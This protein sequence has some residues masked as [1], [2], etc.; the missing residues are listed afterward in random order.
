MW[1][2]SPASCGE[3][4]APPQPVVPPRRRLGRAGNKRPPGIQELRARFARDRAAEEAVEK[5]AFAARRARGGRPRKVIACSRTE[6]PTD[7]A[8]QG[9]EHI[10]RSIGAPLHRS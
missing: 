8:E 6:T 1:A 2:P 5:I 7:S 3:D 10:V 4:E 9:L